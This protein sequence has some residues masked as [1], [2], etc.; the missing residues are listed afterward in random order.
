M[1]KQERVIMLF[2]AQSF[3]ASVEKAAHPQYRDK[4]V[5]VAGDPAR[6]TGIVLAA[7]PLAKKYGV[8]TAERLGEA[9]KKCPEL[10]VIR[11]SMSEYIKVSLQ[12]TEILRSYTDLVEPYSID[13]QFADMTASL[14]LF[15]SAEAI[16]ASVQAKIKND[17]GIYVR[18]GISSNK[19]LSKMACD[20]FAKKNATGIFTLPPNDIAT[21]LWP[22]PI[23]DMFM[24]GSR[25]ARHLLRMHIRTIGDLAQK[26]LQTLTN[27]W[28]VNGEVIWRIANGMDSSPV[29]VH[30]YDA[31]KGIGQQM[32]LPRDYATLE[33]IE[34][35]I[36]ELSELV[37]QRSRAKGYAGWVVNVGCQGAD[38]DRPFGFYRQRK[39]ADPTNITDE[40]YPVACE[41]F[42][43]H[44]NGLPIRKIAVALTELVEDREYQLL[45]FTDREKKRRLERATDAIKERFGNSAIMRAISLTAA[46]QARDRAQKIGGHYK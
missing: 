16:A 19:V 42:R 41:I 35:V 33:E 20:N 18:A 14:K 17:T 5:V 25:M 6:R 27:R 21:L 37:C 36:L 28:G 29:S 12:I 43:L 44:W 7:C 11:P 22:L 8:T 23:Q 24:I 3:Y 40:V 4:P 1:N 13:E 32:T 39:I 2:D 10:V 31:Q 9:L 34:T 46:G 26:P 45:L 38:F 15:G 30:T